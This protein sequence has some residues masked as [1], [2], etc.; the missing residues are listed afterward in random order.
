MLEMGLDYLDGVLSVSN[1]WLVSGLGNLAGLFSVLLGWWMI[2]Y[3]FISLRKVFQQS[4]MMTISK[5]V[6][7]GVIYFALISIGFI[8]TLLA[9]A[10]FV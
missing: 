3:V 4:W 6:L 5:G 9:G 2:L 1:N 7:L 10:Y 8:V